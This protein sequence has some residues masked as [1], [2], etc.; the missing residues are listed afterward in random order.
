MKKI[1]IRVLLIGVVAAAVGYGTSAF[2]SDTETS[3]D[4]TFR[5]GA[6]DLRVDSEAHYNGLECI[7]GQWTNSCQESGLN[8]LVNGGFE[9]PVVVNGAKWDIF[10]DGTPGIGWSVAWV[11]PAAV[12]QSQNAPNPSLQE[13]HRGVNGWLPQEGNQYAELDSDWKGPN[14]PLN[15]EP[16]L[17]TI[18]QTVVT[19]PGKKYYLTYWFSPRPGT[20]AGQNQM[21]VKI[22]GVTVESPSGAGGG[23]TSWIKYS[24]EFTGDGSTVV[25]FIGGGTNDS[26]GIF[27]DNVSVREQKCS[28]E[29]NDYV[30]RACAS[31]WTETDLGPTN[32]FFNF[33]DIKPGDQGE[34]TISLHVLD[35]D[36]YACM[37]TS[38]MHDNDPLLV[39]PETT[40]GD[41]SLGP[42]L[43]EL[44]K[45]T[46]FFVWNDDGDNIWEEGETPITQGPVAGDVFLNNGVY[47]LAN[48]LGGETKYIGLAWCAGSMTAENYVITCD[49]TGMDNTAQVDELKAD[50][51][52][53]VEQVRNNPEFSCS[54]LIER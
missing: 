53:Y 3:A 20:D 50:I 39:E 28:S 46:Y 35:N 8:M 36:A 24:N 49:G 31:A 43:G 38:N 44:A 1:A 10:P 14:D 45:Q 51:S 26:L 12:Y 41:L 48:I 15:N 52:F 29:F 32:Q 5:T 34:N 4:N 9:T 2:F 42:D 6:I 33:D 23:Q 16:A 7:D 21:T 17:V 27:L 54:K 47:Q 25:E 22:D 37:Y 11:N 40:A 18:S 19:D 30:G 13:Y